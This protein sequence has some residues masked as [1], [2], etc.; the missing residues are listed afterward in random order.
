M[1]SLKAKE[2]TV[3]VVLL[4]LVLFASV[5]STPALGANGDTSRYLQL[6]SDVTVSSSSYVLSV[7]VTFPEATQ[8]LLQSDGRLVPYFGKAQVYMSLSVDSTDVGSSAVLDWVGSTNVQQHSYNT[9]GAVTVS[10]GT[11]T[12]ALRAWSMNGVAFKVGSG[13]NLCVMANPAANVQVATL[14]ADSQLFNF[15]TNGINDGTPVPHTPILSLNVNNTS[16]PIIALGAAR[17]FGN[18]GDAMMRIYKNGA[19]LSN[20][21]AMWSV[22]DIWKGAELQ[23]PLYTHAFINATGQ[24][25]ISLD[26]TEFPWEG[27]EDTVQYRM[28]GGSKLIC[29]YGG[30]TVA[31][32]VPVSTSYD[33]RWEWTNI[34][35]NNTFEVAS[36]T[37]NIPQGHNGVVM[38][39]TKTRIQCDGSDAGGT[40]SLWIT[41]DGNAVGSAG[42]QQIASP[43]GASQRSLC[44]SYLAAGSSALSAGNHTV[45]VYARADGSFKHPCIV[46]DLP[47]LWFD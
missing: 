30:M 23:A 25:T 3:K 17:A 2:R 5:F 31:G 11:H 7:T 44:A 35:A 20:A 37:I 15:T 39:T 19:S 13:S 46:K 1:K 14:A 42:V 18:D 28:G 40:V 27:R 22:N 38:F 6:A 36:A 16:G 33:S 12:F 4:C 34:L 9:I 32:S 47:L 43:D 21:E 45:K 8:V 26:A 29:L 41:I 24:H 10:A